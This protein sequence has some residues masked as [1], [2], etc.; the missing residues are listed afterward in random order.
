MRLILG[1]ELR[2]HAEGI[3]G[4]ELGTMH[5]IG[6][7]RECRTAPSPDIAMRFVENTI[8]LQRL[9][10]VFPEDL[11]SPTDTIVGNVAS[12]QDLVGPAK[13]KPCVEVSVQDGGSLTEPTR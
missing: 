6:A 8:R 12:K 2:D 1:P 5:V 11:A 4:S 10:T 13:P 7:T 9:D 3:V